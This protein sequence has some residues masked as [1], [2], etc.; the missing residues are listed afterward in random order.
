MEL[1]R[2]YNE[3]CIE[4]MKRMEDDSIN[5]IL[6]DPPYNITNADWEYDIDIEFLFYNWLRV[7][8]SNGVIILF[9]M[10]PFTSGLIQAQ[11][12]LFKYKWIWDKEDAGGFLNAYKR[13]LSSFDR[14]WETK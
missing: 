6:T 7:L 2:I 10:E 5:L 3:D 8:K 12:G 4:T 13:P 14:D 1:N 11:K 9:S